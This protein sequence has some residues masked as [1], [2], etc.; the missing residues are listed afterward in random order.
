MIEIDDPVCPAIEPPLL[1]HYISTLLCTFRR[2]ASLNFT[3][4]FGRCVGLHTTQ[5]RALDSRWVLREWSI[6]A[7]FMTFLARFCWNSVGGFTFDVSPTLNEYKT[8]YAMVSTTDLKV[9]N[10]SIMC[11]EI[12]TPRS[13]Q[14]A[15]MVRLQTVNQA[16]SVN[17]LS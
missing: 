13:Y 12:Q 15:V 17:I 7:V 6:N 16:F 9:G 2:I 10:L 14:T 8:N 3:N 4:E 11:F 1:L 5:Y